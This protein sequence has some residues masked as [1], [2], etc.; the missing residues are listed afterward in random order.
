M[1]RTDKLPQK[2]EITVVHSRRIWTG[3]HQRRENI[4]SA[5]LVMEDYPVR[6]LLEKENSF[7]FEPGDAVVI[8]EV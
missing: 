8:F 2:G 6:S 7:V 1:A 3:C 5:C 4:R